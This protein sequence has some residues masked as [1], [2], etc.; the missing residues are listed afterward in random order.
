ML[1]SWYIGFF[2]I[3]G[4]AERLVVGHDYARA[5]ALR[6]GNALAPSATKISPITSV[7]GRLRRLHQY[8]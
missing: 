2:Q 7:P 5:R 1:K 3:P 8:D 4:L 6:G